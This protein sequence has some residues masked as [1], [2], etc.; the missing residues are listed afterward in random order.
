MV[1]KD[2]KPVNEESYLRKSVDL[3]AV[4]G[5]SYVSPWAI[6][7]GAQYAPSVLS[8]GAEKTEFA[9]SHLAFLDLGFKLGY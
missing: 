9:Y 2:G 7:A 8:I 1:W 6:F 5:L 4:G 3:G